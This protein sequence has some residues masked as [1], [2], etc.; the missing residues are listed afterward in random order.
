LECGIFAAAAADFLP[1]FFAAD[2]D[3]T[4]V[5]GLRVG[6]LVAIFNST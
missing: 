4:E 5:V 6:A 1:A 3:E 2:F